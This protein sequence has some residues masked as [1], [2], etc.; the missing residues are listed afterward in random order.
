[1]LHN[2]ELSLCWLLLFIA[3][4]LYIKILLLPQ[5]SKIFCYSNPFMCSPAHFFSAQSY[6]R[7]WE[8]KR[9]ESRHLFPFSY[10]YSTMKAAGVPASQCNGKKV[11]WQNLRMKPYFSFLLEFTNIC[12]SCYIFKVIKIYLFCY[13]LPKKAILHFCHVCLNFHKFIYSNLGYLNQWHA[14]AVII[15]YLWTKYTSLCSYIK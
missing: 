4:L 2:S 11:E 15:K 10:C 5:V 9:G 8:R 7:E 3:F 1:M 12:F 14:T 6:K 13:F